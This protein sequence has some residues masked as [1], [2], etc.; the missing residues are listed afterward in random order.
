MS[1]FSDL[2]PSPVAFSPT[3]PASSGLEL[4]LAD[5]TSP[6]PAESKSVAFAASSIAASSGDMLLLLLLGFRSCGKPLVA[7]SM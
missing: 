4:L 1:T 5:T 6:A 3:L 2:V 7:V